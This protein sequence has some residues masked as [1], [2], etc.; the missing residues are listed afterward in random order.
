[1]CSNSEAFR[2]GLDIGSTTA[3]RVVLDSSG[4]VQ[5]S[6]YRRHKADVLK[7][8]LT[9]LNHLQQK[10]GNVSMSPVFTGSAETAISVFRAVCI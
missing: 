8:L 3:N 2:L 6:D 10:M 4:H 1:M 5:Y 7:T 9:M